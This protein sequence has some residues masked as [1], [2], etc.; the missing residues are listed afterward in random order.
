MASR[1]RIFSTSQIVNILIHKER[2]KS[3]IIF[4]KR[5]C[6][7]LDSAPPKKTFGRKLLLG[8]A[9]V[10]VGTGLYNYFNPPKQESKY[11]SGVALTELTD[12]TRN[13]NIIDIKPSREVSGPATALGLDLTLYQYQTC[14]FCCKVRAFLEFYGIPYK[15]IEVNP[16]MRQQLKFSKYKKVPILIAQEKNSSKKH[17]LN[18]SSVIISI[19]GS[20][21]IDLSSGLE[22]VLKYYVPLSYTNDEGKAVE[23]VMNKYFLMFGDNYKH[24]SDNADYLKKERQWRRWADSEFVHMLSPNIYRTYDEALQAFNYFSEVGEWEK[25]FSTIERLIVIYV[26]ATAMYFVGKKLKKK[27]ALKE[28]VRQSLY[29]ACKKWTKEVG[30]KRK[31]MGGELPNLADL[32]VYGMLSSIEGCLAFQDLLANTNIGPWYYNVKE[33]VNNHYGYQKLK[34]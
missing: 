24:T 7:V 9:A 10:G 29:D 22:S 25:N 13:D 30:S 2:Q 26:G 15:V 20:L 6:S 33:T 1:L 17:Q 27:H 11:R 3:S 31:F 16:V 18:D 34:N 4:Q 32:A 23:E 21:F 14:P 12:F 19:L 8:L 28:D 5:W